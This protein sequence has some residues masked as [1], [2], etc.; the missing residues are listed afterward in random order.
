VTA[1][2]S[3]LLFFTLELNN[4]RDRDVEDKKPSHGSVR[5]RP[6]GVPTA[7][8]NLPLLRQPFWPKPIEFWKYL[9]E[10]KH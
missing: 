10:S 8:F 3:H 4:A 9:L 1:V 6:M 7:I 2:S 5:G